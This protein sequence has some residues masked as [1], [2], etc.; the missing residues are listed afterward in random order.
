MPWTNATP[1]PTAR[2]GLAAATSD[3]PT[4]GSGYRIYAIGGNS[5]ASVVATVEAYDTHAKTWSPVAPMPTARE[6]LAATSG[7]A[8]LYAIGG[9]NGVGPLA[10]HEI[11]DPAA[12]TWAAAPALPTARTG[13]AAATGRDG[14]IY[15]IGG[16]NGAYLQ[17]VEAFDPTTNAWTTKTPM[18]TGRYRL[19]AVTGPDGLI[20]AI[21]GQT[22][23]ATLDTVEVF[24]PVANTWSTGHAMPA[25][26]ASLAAAVGPDGLIYAIGGIDGNGGLQNTVY[27]Y[28]PAAP[29]PW[30]VQASLLMVQ[31]FLA[32]DTGPDGLIYAIGGQNPA[33]A[34]SS[35]EAFTIATASVAPDPYIGNGTYQSPDIIL[36]GA[37]GTPIPIGGAPGGAWDTLLTF[38]SSFGIQAV[39][40]NDSTVAAANT[41]VGF[42][43]FP[44][45]VGS[46]GAVGCTVS[47][48]A[49]GAPYG[50]CSVPS[51]TSGVNR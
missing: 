5:A 42:W 16:F 36:L 3:A 11:Y 50:G 1:L 8:R 43:H 32:A 30:S 2:Q 7:T 14:R 20:Y 12:G 38:N 44:G 41:V 24:D 28:N 21:G 26:R 51:N 6:S 46:A 47:T 19:A 37:G 45:G 23:A 13:L 49:C 4:P 35:V 33:P 25:V 39:I 40:Y 29:G 31:A 27:S 34:S 15:A 22:A 9:D 10:T 48:I 18:P 17:T